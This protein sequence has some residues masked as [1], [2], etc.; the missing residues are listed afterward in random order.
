MPREP[1]YADERRNFSAR[2]GILPTLPW[3]AAAGWC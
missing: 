3:P 1:A 2:L